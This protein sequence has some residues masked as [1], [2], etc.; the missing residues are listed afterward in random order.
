MGVALLGMVLLG[1][2]LLETGGSFGVAIWKLRVRHAL[3]VAPLVVALM[4]VTLLWVALSG[5]ALLGSPLKSL[6]SAT[7]YT[8]VALLRWCWRWW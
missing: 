5:L 1:V 7:L 8:W 2:A 6:G 3:Q 4:G